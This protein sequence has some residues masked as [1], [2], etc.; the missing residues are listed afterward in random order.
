MKIDIKAKIKN[1]A[2]QVK[3]AA[4][5]GVDGFK[6]VWG[7]KLGKAAVISVMA[8]SVAGAGLGIGYGVTTSRNNKQDFPAIVQLEKTP[9][10]IKREEQIEKE[11]TSKTQILTGIENVLND[12]FNIEKPEENIMEG[13][14]IFSISLNKQR[15]VAFYDMA[16]TV[17]VPEGEKSYTIIYSKVTER[18]LEELEMDELASI[19][20]DFV[21]YGEDKMVVFEDAR[22]FKSGFE[23]TDSAIKYLNGEEFEEEIKKGTK[24]VEKIT[25][26]TQSSPSAPVVEEPPVQG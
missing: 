25:P 3:K 18:N 11:K 4:T 14:K 10:Q 21:T 20:L 2:T 5:K 23:A 7:T 13:A 1:A 16:I 9:E 24:V 15:G 12:N 6:K 17:L 22:M 19:V 8:L 26:P